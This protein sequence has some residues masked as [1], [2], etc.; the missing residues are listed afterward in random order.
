MA[1]MIEL[2]QTQEVAAALEICLEEVEVAIDEFSS[3]VGEV[4]A[5]SDRETLERLLRRKFEMENFREAVKDLQKR[6]ARM[7]NG[8]GKKRKKKKLPRGLRTPQEQFVRPLLEAL[9]ELGGT[10]RAAEVIDLVGK[11]MEK[12]L[13]EHDREKLSSTGQPRW[14][15]TVQWCRLDLVREGLLSPDSPHGIWEITEKGKAYLESL[16]R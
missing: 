8:R 15:N 9:E 12:E 3:K 11:K 13:N 1:K 6:W 10:A 4:F 5:E 14:R 16:K 2:E 7:W